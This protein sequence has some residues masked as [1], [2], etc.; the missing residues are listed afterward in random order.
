MCTKNTLKL[1]SSHAARLLLI[2]LIS[3]QQAAQEAKI[4]SAGKD[5]QQ[6]NAED[7]DGAIGV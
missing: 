1:F 5:A 4:E 7:D 6:R 2:F 3:T